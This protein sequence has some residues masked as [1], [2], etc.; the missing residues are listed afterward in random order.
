MALAFRLEGGTIRSR[1]ILV[2]LVALVPVAALTAWQTG[3]NYDASREMVAD[4]LRSHAWAIAETERD[5]FVIA[6]HTLAFGAQQPA[7]RDISAGCNEMLRAAL[8]ETEGI[9]NFLRVDAQGKVRCSALAFMPGTDVSRDPWW[10]EAQDRTELFVAAPMIG[11]VSGKPILAMVQPLRDSAG[12]MA[13]SLNAGIGL[14]SL[15]AS[16]HRKA[17]ERPGHAFVVDRQGHTLLRVDGPQFDRIARIGL[18]RSQALEVEARDGSEWTLVSAPLFGDA[19]S[20]VYAEPSQAIMAAQVAQL[21]YAMALQVLTLILTSLAIWIGSQRLILR[22]LRRLQALTARFAAGDFTGERAAY[23][24]APVE[25]A[26]LSGHLHDM[27]EAIDRN[28]LQQRRAL[29]IEAKLT[30]EVHHR[31]RNNLQIV[32]SL[33]TLQGQR[34]SDPEARLAIDQARARISALGLIHRLLY[35]EGRGGEQGAIDMRHLLSELCAQQRSANRSRQEVSLECSAQD[36]TLPV[37]QAVPLTLFTLEAITN[38]FRHA[39]PDGASGTI[40]VN[41]SVEDGQARMRITDDGGGFKP[42]A[43]QAQMGIELMQ[44]FATQLEGSLDISSGDRGSTLLLRFPA[45]PP[46]PAPGE[47]AQA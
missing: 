17:R 36:F 11:R 33:L 20:I 8:R 7:V 43:G 30:R 21:R 12:R 46:P 27:A 39:F 44:A 40:A 16:L 34:L 13:G 9:V 42:E 4:R 31:V 19:L 22:W 1:L 2:V 45:A 29:V 24:E 23:A 25:I 5:P 18:A 38:A 28:E 15:A 6:R 41:F 3:Q 37:D 10:A 32:T 47:A 26:E 14:E 35:E